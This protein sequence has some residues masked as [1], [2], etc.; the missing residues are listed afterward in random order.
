MK[1]IF[2]NDKLLNYCKFKY[3]NLHFFIVGF[4]VVNR[5][6]IQARKSPKIKFNQKHV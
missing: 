2:H 3:F 1:N 5:P 4:R 6:T